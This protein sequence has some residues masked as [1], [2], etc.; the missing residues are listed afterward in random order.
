[1][2]EFGVLVLY[3]VVLGVPENG[4]LSLKHVGEFRVCGLLFTVLY[5]LYAL[6]GVCG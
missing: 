1:M 4:D 6:V 3:A 5:E 2:C